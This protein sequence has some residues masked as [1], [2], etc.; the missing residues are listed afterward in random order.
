MGIEL[1]YNAQLI[2][3]PVRGFENGGHHFPAAESALPAVIEPSA[4]ISSS[5]HCHYFCVAVHVA[6]VIA[7]TSLQCAD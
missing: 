4:N 5:P 6:S 1:H 7:A 2:I 3:E